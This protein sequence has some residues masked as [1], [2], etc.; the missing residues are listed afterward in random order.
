MIDRILEVKRQEVRAMNGRRLKERN[1][2]VIPFT[3]EGP[4]NIIAELKRKSPSAGFIANIDNGRIETYSRYARAISVLTD[5]TF[6]GGS[7]EFLAHVANHT[8]LPVLCKDFILHHSQIDAAYSAGADL[9]LLIVRILTAEELGA[10]YTYA[11]DRGLECLVELHTEEDLLKI[12]DIAPIAVG[13][14][15]RDLDTLSIDQVRTSSILEGIN[16]Q[17]RVAESG[18][19][20]RGD[21]Q[22]YMPS[23]NAFLVGET[24]MRSL[25]LDATFRELLDGQD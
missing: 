21:I 20:S 25:N 5:E 12:Q 7:M 17:V 9:I 16:A 15:A 8:P 18:I 3:T 23:A 4:V 14:N 2:T 22:R 11:R 13:V 24:L 1:K 6:F 19:K 10:L